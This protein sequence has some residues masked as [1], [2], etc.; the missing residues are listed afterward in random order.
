MQRVGAA[1]TILP[2]A[3]AGAPMQNSRR[4][5]PRPQG[6]NFLIEQ[7]KK[8]IGPQLKTNSLVTSVKTSDKKVTVYFMEVHTGIVKAVEAEQCIIAV[9]QFVAARSAE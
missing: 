3:R 1:S 8:D 4:A 7:L 9:P 5:Y 2:P 6:N